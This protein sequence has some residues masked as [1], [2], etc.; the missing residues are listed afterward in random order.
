M[1]RWSGRDMADCSKLW[2]VGEWGLGDQIQFARYAKLF[3]N[4][5]MVVDPCLVRLLKP[6]TDNVVPFGSTC[7]NRHARYVPMMSLPLWHETTPKTIPFADGY[8]PCPRIS[9]PTKIGLVWH[10]NLQ[11]DPS[12]SPG[13]AALEPLAKLGLDFVS[14]QRAEA[15]P[16]WMASS[17]AL[18]MKP[19]AFYDTIRLLPEMKLVVTC[20]TSIAHLCGAMGIPAW[21]VLKANCDWRWGQHGRTTPWYSSVRLFRQRTPGSWKSVY[22]DIAQAL[23]RL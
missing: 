21:V 22:E 23:K 18:D 20:D 1:M 19:D 13:L 7:A 2:I 4:C 14:L 11:T 16:S 15:A 12:R 9:G 8:L 17:G 6:I 10:G 3:P 5:T